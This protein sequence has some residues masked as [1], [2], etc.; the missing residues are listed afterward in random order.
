MILGQVEEIWVDLTEDAANV[1]NGER[2][3]GTQAVDLFIIKLDS[4]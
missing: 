1:T 3:A 4:L 2:R